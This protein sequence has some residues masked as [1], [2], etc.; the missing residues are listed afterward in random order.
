MIVDVAAF[1][2]DRDG[3]QNRVDVLRPE[4][5]LGRGEGSRGITAFLFTI[6]LVVILRRQDESSQDNPF[7]YSVNT[8]K[9]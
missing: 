2:D 9:G 1:F 7:V 5:R 4:F 8:R 6:F 3:V